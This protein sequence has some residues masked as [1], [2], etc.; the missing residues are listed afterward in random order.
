MYFRPTITLSAMLLAAFG[1]VQAQE[2]DQTGEFDSDETALDSV[3]I[4]GRQ[5]DIADVAGS[6]HVVTQEELAT[7]IHSDIM[8]VLRSVPG[9]YVQEEEGFGLRPNIGIRGSGL[10]RSRRIA[11][12]ED[13]VFIAPA[14]YAAPPAYY[15]PTQR[16]MYELEVLKGL[17]AVAVGPRT[18]GGAINMLSTPIPDSMGGLIDLRIGENS[19]TDAHMHFGDRG[20]RFSWLLETVQIENDG[21]KHIDGAP[22]ETT[23][24]EL[25]DYVAKAQFD[26]DPAAPFYQS[27]RLKAGYTEQVADETYLGLTD[28]DFKVDPYRRY[29]ASSGDVFESQH[30]QAQLSYVVDSGKRWSGEVTI[31]SNQFS[32]N[33]FKVDKVNGIAIDSVLADTA[34]YATEYGYMQGSDSP[35]D[36]IIKRNFN[37]EYYSRGIQAEVEWDFQFGDSEL[38]LTTGIRLHDDGEDRFEDENGHRME[39][40]ALVM[41]TDG[42][43]GSKTNR[44]SKAEV[45]SVFVDSEFRTGNWI[46]SPGVRFEDIDMERLDFSTSDPSRELD[47][48]IKQNSLSVVIPGMGVLYRLNEEWRLLGG[49][50]KGY[51][52]PSPGSTAKEET[53]LNI[54]LGAR[55]DNGSLA[56][57]SI[58]YLNDYDNLVGT[59]TPATGGGAEDGS[60]FDGGNVAVH[61]LELAAD[62]TWEGIGNS[63]LDLPVSLR[64][65]WTTESEFENAFDSSYDPWGN[66]LVGDALPYIPDHQLSAT[67][68]LQAESWALNLAASYT[69]EMRSVAGQGAIE[70][71]ELIDSHIVWDI[72]T[73]WQMT[74]KIMT[75]FKVDNLFDETY[76]AAR[77]PAGARPG[78]D[79]TAYIG[80]MVKI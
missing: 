38:G 49:I 52:P 4:I 11:L 57:E 46:L 37:R 62:Y 9:V 24:Y 53:G 70:S 64:Y 28:E 59:A 58:Y 29:A 6:A 51:N 27:L 18:T 16:R 79:R 47:P 68:S 66:V 21:F 65:T 73:S 26:S 71:T 23:G 7:F 75:Y 50:H 41:T 15:F 30:D 3:T 72:V 31:Y 10:D 34:T 76:I 8:R 25:E 1:S 63:R 48:S 33:W 43:P 55:Y 14:P 78:L 12:L 40:G 13:G 74:P 35:D 80:F 5:S 17:A 67:A 22:G 61:G 60:E 69:G 77:R 36:A 54:E 44:I 56:F 42:V 19:T 20:D 45:I 32:R 2:N 39:N